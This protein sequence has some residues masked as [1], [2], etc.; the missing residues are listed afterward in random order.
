MTS[1]GMTA[2]LV[3]E[4]VPGSLFTVIDEHSGEAVVRRRVPAEPGSKLDR[5][6][7]LHS[8]LRQAGYVAPPGVD[9][10]HAGLQWWAIC[11]TV[12]QRNITTESE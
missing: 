2:W 1:K 3:H 5:E 7:T 8:L 11:Q 6:A 10:Y 12:T 4:E 9:F